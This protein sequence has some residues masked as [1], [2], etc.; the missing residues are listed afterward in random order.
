MVVAVAGAKVA[1]E[2]LAKYMDESMAV[3]VCLLAA[4]RSGDSSDA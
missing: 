1:F 2:T 4:A 3:A